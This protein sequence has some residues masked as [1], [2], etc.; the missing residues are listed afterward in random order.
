MELTLEGHVAVVTGAGARLGKAIAEGLGARGATVVV[1]YASSRDGAEEVAQRIRAGGSQ[2]VTVQ[3]DLS[4][5]EEVARV[6]AQAD[7]LG[8]CDLLVNS[9]A[10]FERLPVEAIDDASWRR[11]LDVNLS[12]PFFCCRSAVPAMRRRG[13]G[14]IVNIVDVGGALHAWRGYA[15]YC[16]AKAGLAM[17]T[18]CLAVELAP[19]IRVNAVA[20]GA[21]L[22]P[23]SYGE[24][25]RQRV[26]ARIPLGHAGSPQDVI[27]AVVYLATA[28]FVTGQ[29]LPVDGGRS[30]A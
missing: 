15:H 20:P 1:H 21:V 9:A 14:A 19:A 4:R 16:A 13:S 27:G 12:G 29:I 6:F 11:M 23:E 5:S 10:I 24:D 26:L 2:A 30:I 22:F 28:P 7:A 3:A 25:E 17:L 8:G 18:R